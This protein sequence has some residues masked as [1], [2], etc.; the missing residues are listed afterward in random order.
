MCRRLM[1]AAVVS[2]GLGA[3]ALE[4]PYEDIVHPTLS[5]KVT[6]CA[7]IAGDTLTVNVPTSQGTGSYAGYATVD[8]TPYEGKPFVMEIEIAG[9]NIAPNDISYYGLKFMMTYKDPQTDKYYYKQAKK[10]EGTFPKQKFLMYDFDTEGRRSATGTL[11][12]G[13][14]NTSGIAVFDLS[15]LQFATGTK[16]WPQ[17]PWAPR[18][19]EDYVVSYPARVT[20]V[21]QLRGVMLP[22][23]NCKEDD[24]RT[25]AEWGATIGRYQ[26]TSAPSLQAGD[27]HET[28][29]ARYDAWLAARLDHL[30]REALPWA[31]KYGIKLVIDLHSPPGGRNADDHG[32]RLF[33]DEVY[34]ERFLEIWREIA[35]RFRGREGVYGY[36]LY[37]EPY[38]ER[39]A[40]WDYWT[41]QRIAAEEVRKIDPD[42]PILI[43]SS[44]MDSCGAFAFLSPLAMDNVIYQAHFYNPGEYT[45]QGVNGSVATNK[46]PDAAKGWNRDYIVKQVASVRA[47]ELKHHAKIYIGEFSAAAWAEGAEQYLADCISVFNEYGWDWTYHA[48][49]EWTGWSVEHETPRGGRAV[50]SEDNPRKRALLSGMRQ[51]DGTGVTRLTTADDTFEG[52]NLGATATQ[53]H[54][55]WSGDGR[56]TGASYQPATPPGYPVPEA[57]H[58]KVL[59]VSEEGAEKDICSTSG[60]NRVVDMMV[61]VLR[62]VGTENMDGD[63]RCAL[64]VDQEGRFRIWHASMEQG[65]RTL[66]WSVLSA[67]T[68]QNDEWVRVGIETAISSA[69]GEMFHRVRINGSYCPTVNGVRSP[70]DPAPYG[71]WYRSARTDDSPVATLQVVNARVDDVRVMSEAVTP[72]HT[73]PTS[74]N[75]VAFSWFDSWGLPRRPDAASP[76][77]PGY[78]LRDVYQSGVHPY[79]DEQLKLTAFH[80]GTD[81]AIDMTLNGILDESAPFC[82][83]VIGAMTSEDLAADRNTTVMPGSFEPDAETWSTTWRGSALSTGERFFRVRSKEIPSN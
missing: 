77:V 52:A 64:T 45:H 39:Q 15:T 9:T 81:G 46:Y 43:E 12:M 57:S 78:S 2:W 40:V 4:A 35:T 42:T 20:G 1:V 59:S 29:L 10:L 53:L 44:Q 75:G 82:Y 83:E 60:V 16:V 41:I 70:D 69:T 3:Q 37:N 47:F 18:T 55:G 76:F 25:L 11:T 30:D 33:D 34:K 54:T 24:F 51:H 49:R 36:D 28:Y 80:I 27:T 6:T 79:E 48:F 26:M 67:D 58:E 19:N 65:V 17:C 73:G 61:S 23:A 50:A 72:G 7:S 21:Q 56:V 32:F 8:L 13:L 68:Y 22:S 66:R 63:A 62:G 71:A 38:Q 5:W 14:Q 31:V 74:T